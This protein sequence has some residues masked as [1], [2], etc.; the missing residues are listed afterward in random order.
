MTAFDAAVT[1]LTRIKFRQRFFEFIPVFG[2]NEKVTLEEI[3]ETGSF[4]AFRDQ[5]VD[6]QIRRRYVKD[7]IG[8]LY[9]VGMNKG[10]NVPRDEQVRLIELV[11]R[12]NVHV[13]N[14]GIVDDRYLEL[15]PSSQ[16]PKYNLHR[17]KIGDAAVIDDAYF[18]EAVE[19]ST[20]FVD[21]LATW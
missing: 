4:E 7:L 12:R 11:L 2:K 1:D 15:D 21:A 20:Q 9:A 14:R 17:L 6:E 8:L 16:K 18:K 10:E 5:V 19:R 3:G 13:H